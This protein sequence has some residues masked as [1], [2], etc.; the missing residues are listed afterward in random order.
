MSSYPLTL[1]LKSLVV[2]GSL[3]TI[4]PEVVHVLDHVGINVFLSVDTGG[5]TG[6]ETDT[7]EVTRGIGSLWRTIRSLRAE[8]E[9]LGAILG[10][11]HP[12]SLRGE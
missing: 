7:S 6:R 5:V 3:C 8:V 10:M 12:T 2:S 11:R 1:E 9:S 4:Q